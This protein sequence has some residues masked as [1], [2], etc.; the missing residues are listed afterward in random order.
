LHE[1]LSYVLIVGLIVVPLV[2]LVFW[3]V[4]VMGAGWRILSALLSL[5][6]A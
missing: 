5:P 6:T 3:L 4:E 1:E 2:L